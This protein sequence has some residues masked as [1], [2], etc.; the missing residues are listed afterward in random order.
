MF[1]KII[2]FISF[3]VLRTTKLKCPIDRTYLSENYGEYGGSEINCIKCGANYSWDVL[4]NSEL[5]IRQA[6][7]YI[8]N[9][10]WCF[11]LSKLPGY[12]KGGMK[13]LREVLEFAQ[14]NIKSLRLSRRERLNLEKLLS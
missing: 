8:D 5:L 11:E 7:L 3:M 12:Y 4:K 1:I 9:L 14:R 10:S 13:D 6:K 2:I